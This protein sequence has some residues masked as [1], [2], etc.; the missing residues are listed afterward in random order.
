[1]RG[2]PSEI[3]LTAPSEEGDG[4]SDYVTLDI[5]TTGSDPWRHD[6]V[7]VGI[8]RNVHA[9][10]KGRAY[11]RMVMSRP[12]TTIVAHTN[13]DLRWLMLDGANL[14][15]GVEFHDTKVLAWLLDATQ[16][17]DLESLAAR[18]LGYVPP[19]LIRMRQGVVCFECSD[20][21]VL[22]IE[23]APWD[24][25]RDYN[26]SDIT[27]EGELY[28]CLRTLLQEQGLWE[29]FITEEAP[30]SRLLVEMEAAGLP[31]DVERT[32][33]MLTDTERRYDALR[34][35][36]VEATGVPEFNPGSGDQVAKFLYEEVCAFPTRFEI[37]RLNGMSA[38]RKLAAVESIAPPGVR[39]K[40][41]GRDYAYGD[42]IVDG[43]GLKPPKPPKWKLEQNPDA[44][45][46]VS[47]ELLNV[48][49][50]GDP[51]VADFI[52]WK[53]AE[54]LRG[55]L[56]DWLD[57]EHDGRLHGRFDQSGT[58]TGRLSGREPNLQQVSSTG[59]VRDLF[60]G[61]LVV[62]DYAGLE[63]RLGAHFSQDPVM[64]EI[65]REGKDLYGVLAAEAWGGP[66]TKENDAR[67]LMKVIWL[68]S[69]YGAQGETL[70]QTMAIAGM[71][72]YTARKAD[73][74]LRDLQNTVPRLFEWREEVIAEARALG[75]VT[76]LAGRKRHLP[77]IGAAEWKKMAKAERQAVN[78]KVQGSAADVVRRAMLACR[79][80]HDP[81]VARIIL[82]VH[83]EILWERGPEWDPSV[84]HEIV[85][86]C[87]HV[88]G[89]DL[90]VP[91]IFEAKVAESWAAKGGSAGQV[92]AGQYEG[93]AHALEAA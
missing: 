47:G 9:P 37:P 51:W 64:L 28:E 82:Q 19:K 41:V 81:A 86:T 13:F 83:D 11:A 79:R 36:L 52:A 43:R 16:E 44:R 59:D 24:E 62:G 1:V 89:F 45:P 35:S 53:K 85:A 3:R 63:A 34:A 72:G 54:K 48:L 22:P 50:G 58:I 10:D 91:L 4:L 88:H 87:E 40:K 77:D 60:R 17:L 93:L 33:V 31:V 68:S 42:V 12:G 76:T 65:F 25:V 70:A 49:H 74:M 73:A 27:T 78:S 66:A 55:Y 15:E 23:E 69:Q 46:S 14:A 5:E 21:Q 30:F 18:Y 75:Y 57:R 56:R 67:G 80:L 8:G 29:H 20:G 71:R 6:L 90:D 38:E 32:A 2:V 39:V 92:Q 61:N 84:F 26:Y 7:C